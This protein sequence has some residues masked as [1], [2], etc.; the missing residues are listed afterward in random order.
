MKT[1]DWQRLQE[2]IQLPPHTPLSTQ[3][4]LLKEDVL[5]LVAEVMRLKNRLSA[6]S[7]AEN[8]LLADLQATADASHRAGADAMRQRALEVCCLACS[9]EILHLTNERPRQ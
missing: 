8:A 6:A 4:E 9:Q 7:E 3:I 2:N 5:K 1:A